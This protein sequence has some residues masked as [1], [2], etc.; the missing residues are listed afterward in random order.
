MANTINSTNNLTSTKI[1]ELY[2][3]YFNPK[4]KINETISI[5]YYVSDSTQ[6]EY[7][8]KDDSKSFTTIVKIMI[9]H[10]LKPLKQENI[11]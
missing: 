3:R 7:L 1:P 2:I 4:Q 5:R 11:Q 8:N 9:S 10:I 6:A